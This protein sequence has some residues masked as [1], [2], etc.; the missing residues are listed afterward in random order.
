MRTIAEKNEHRTVPC[1]FGHT[2]L[3]IEYGPDKSRVLSDIHSV[4]KYY[5]DNLFEQKIES[6]KISNTNYIF[7]FGKAIA[8][9]SQVDNGKRDI[10]YLHHDHLGSIQAFSDELGKLYQE[11]SYDAWGLRRNPDT[12]V[13]FDVVASSN[14]YNEH[15]FGGHEHIDLFELV[16]MDGRM[17]DPVVGRFISADPFIQSPDF[18]Q[19][20]NR[21]AYCIN[22]PLS[23]I[24]PSGCSWF[25]KNWKSITASIV[26][27]AVSAVTLGSGTTIGA[28]IIAGAAGGA[29]GAL[30]GALLNGANIG[31]IAKSTFTGALVGGA[32]GFFNFASGDGTIWEQLF[33]HTFSQGWLEGVQGGNVFHGFMTGAINYAGNSS[34]TKFGDGM[35][36]VGM[37]ASS[38]VLG[39]TVSEIGGG[40]FANG[41]ITSAYSMI[42]NDMMHHFSDAK[43]K[44]IYDAY[45]SGSTKTINGIKSW[46]SA[47]ELCLNI[48][49]ELT[50]V[51]KGIENSCALRL[52]IA[53]N[54][55]GFAISSNA[56]GAKLGGDGRY[57]IISAK[58][59][60]TYLSN[61]KI[62]TV[63]QG[64]RVKNGLVYQYPN[65]SWRLQGITGHVDVVYRRRW[66]SIYL[67]DVIGAPYNN[68]RTEVFH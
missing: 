5:V 19:S 8:I 47:K 35:G 57:Y 2:I 10:K 23:L 46:M 48:G 49:G 53:L 58:N 29:A 42:F 60:Q 25:S 38:A 56:P 30:T 68:F 14:A 26:G 16:N 44:K 1:S 17:Y 41:A 52:S 63:G 62:I 24:D 64:N 22:N 65:D 12:W 3:R 15:G 9:V 6:S 67:R 37:I 31:Q 61:Y 32:S 27:I 36:K 20:L 11:L 51:A 4:R 33:K 40:K 55:A 18:T 21:Y 34:I 66:A 50:E 7:A 39:G 59:M 13:V 45:I 54:D 28:A 43:L